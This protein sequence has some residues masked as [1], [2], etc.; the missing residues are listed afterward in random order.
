[1]A[2]HTPELENLLRSDLTPKEESNGKTGIEQE[3]VPLNDI[4]ETIES[5]VANKDS[6]ENIVATQKQ[7]SQVKQ[8]LG[9][10]IDTMAQNPSLFTRAS[11]YFGEMLLW[12]KIAIGVGLSVPTLAAGIFAHVGILLVISGVTVLTYTAA[13]IILD[14]HHSCNVDIADRLKAGIFNLADVLQLTIDALDAIRLKLAEEIEKFK[15][16]N[17]KLAQHVVDLGTNIEKLSFQV[18]LYMAT[19]KLL[20]ATKDALE[21]TA[22]QLKQSVT[23]QT[24]LLQENQLEL[25]HVTKSYKKSQEQ[26]SEKV[27]ELNSVKVEMGL[28]VEKAQKIAV[29]L[30]GA[31]TTLSGTVISDSKQ[32]ED[33][34]KRLEGF[35]SDKEK[36]FDQVAERIFEAERELASVKDELRVVKDELNRSLENHRALL[37]EQG[38][39][40]N[41][42]EAIP[43]K[44]PLAPP[45]KRAQPVNGKENMAEILSLKGIYAHKSVGDTP[46]NQKDVYSLATPTSGIDM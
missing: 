3:T 7:L 45:A 25:E 17:I 13:G 1:M 15:A 33:F 31:V 40:L 42:L 27:V 5:L 46:I 37:V 38:K 30:Q 4:P 22:A 6:L 21:E 26:L 44:T 24:D 11:T 28:E 9:T 14:D 43:S 20:R 12:Q 18:Q 35:L 10:I 32:R 23:E 41:R 2:T 19:E 34:Q 36:S 8:S 39:Q 29:T 16:E